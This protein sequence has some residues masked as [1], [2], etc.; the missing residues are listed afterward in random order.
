MLHRRAHI[1]LSVAICALLGSVVDAA[2]GSEQPGDSSSSLTPRLS[3]GDFVEELPKAAQGIEINEKIGAQVPL[4]LEFRDSDGRAVKLAELLDGSLP[5]I[6]T[7]NYSSCPMLCSSQLNGLVESMRKI[8]FTVGDQ[9]RVIT[10]AIDP[11]ET[12]D[13]ARDT[14][15]KYIAAFAKEEKQALIR[16][17]WSFLTGQEAS[18]KA[19]ADAVGFTY[20]YLDETKEYAHAASLI[21]L[22]PKGIVTRY[23]HG[24]YYEPDQLSTSIFQ[25]GAGE[26]G[27][28][29]G[30]LLACF[31]PSH[32]EGRADSGVAAMRYGALG[33]VIFLLA[34]FGTWQMMRARGARQESIG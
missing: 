12:P 27:V 9:Y 25:A 16:D 21:F 20:R 31:R 13:S 23:Y 5:V 33:F 1:G 17:G 32:Q 10:V 11:L 6:L 7:F 29:V 30:F 22:S 15:D 2:A 8:A 34:A 26:H 4:D 28:S 18:I 14:K 24:I 3:D 19:F